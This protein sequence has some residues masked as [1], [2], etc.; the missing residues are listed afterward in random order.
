M[1]F[2]KERKK[3]RLSKGDCRRQA[4]QVCVLELD[5]QRSLIMSHRMPEGKFAVCLPFPFYGRRRK[6]IVVCLRDHNFLSTRRYWHG[7]RGHY[8]YVP[9]NFT[10]FRPGKVG[11][12]GGSDCRAKIL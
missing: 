5:E 8:V 11:K 3:E 9:G 7:G 4:A 1:E 10:R 2:A 6:S 12:G